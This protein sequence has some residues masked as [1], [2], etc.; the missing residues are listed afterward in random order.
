M[1][2]EVEPRDGRPAVPDLPGL[3]VDP[4][5][6]DG[7]LG[8]PGLRTVDLRDAE[9]YRIGHIPGA[10]HVDLEELGSSGGGR[11]NVLIPPV[12]F[13]DLMTER[14]ISS[15]E[16]IIAYDDQW[17]LA[18]ARLLWACHYYGHRK[19]AVLNGGW[20]R[21]RDEGRPVASGAKGREGPGVGVRFQA[22]PRPEL[23]ADTE[24]I[25]RHIE[26][27]DATLVDAR[28]PAE[29]EGGHLPGAVSWD[30]F[31]AV[32][33]GSWDA[34]RDPEELRAEWRAL[35][36]DPSREVTVYCRSGMRAAHTW[37]VLR[38]A[39]FE[40]VRLYDGS[41]Q[42]WSTKMEDVLGD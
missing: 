40:R 36:I 14:G 30:W 2:S 37:L 21:W 28:T 42:E 35:G 16:G 38:N 31:N 26:A 22:T 13:S 20:D 7:H 1:S 33:A 6:L 12:E 32:P 34:S 10:A 41:W 19:A 17:G 24:W 9:A 11:D 39:G 23:Y 3:F 18:A 15:G 29:F 25:V 27:G 4:A 8:K 5:W